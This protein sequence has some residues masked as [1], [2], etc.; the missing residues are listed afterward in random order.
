MYTLEKVGSIWSTYTLGN[1]GSSQGTLGTCPR[2][3]PWLEGPG[4]CVHTCVRVCVHSCGV[5][6]H[7]HK[8]KN[9]Y[10]R[11]HGCVFTCRCICMGACTCV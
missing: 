3:G 4:R 6:V 11:V 1:V 8:C 9:V 7:L 10:A 2:H 5:Y